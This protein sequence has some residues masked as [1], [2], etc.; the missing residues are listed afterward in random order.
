MNDTTSGELFY[1]NSIG[2]E[3]RC[4]KNTEEGWKPCSI[5]DIKLFNESQKNKKKVIKKAASNPYGY[6]GKFSTKNNTFCIAEVDE[7]AEKKYKLKKGDTRFLKTGVKCG[8]ST[9]C[10]A[11][12][13]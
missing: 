9:K 2:D 1:V 5:D 4:L 10:H 3:L 12:C 11:S 8:T 13:L 7:E 6:Y